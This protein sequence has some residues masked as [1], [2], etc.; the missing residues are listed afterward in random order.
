MTAQ[1][2]PG[3]P[4]T[5]GAQTARRVVIA[6]SVLACDFGRLADE[7]RAVEAA[8]ADWIHL[9]VMDGHFVPNISFGPVV[10]KAIRKITKLPLDA[11]LMIEHPEKYVPAFI[12]AGCNHISVHVESRGLQDPNVLRGL[13]R[14]MRQ[15]KVRAGLS[16][17]PGTPNEAL[18]P[19]LDE[20]DMLLVM[21]VEP[22]FGGQ[23][24]LPAAL[25]KIRQFRSWF[26][27]DLEVDGGI[28]PE[29]ARQAIAAGANALVA[30]TSVFSHPDYRAAITALRAS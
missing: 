12:D 1:T 7:V 16:L 19:Y 27:G 9:D 24:F 4:T 17:R 5:A 21:S 14:D 20:I 25:D 23:K 29:T 30:G 10:V 15:Q 6:P 2:T 28:T 22:G 13:L 26:S 11:Q 3:T 18:K 8:G